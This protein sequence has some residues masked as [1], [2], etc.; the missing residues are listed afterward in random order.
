[1]KHTNNNK[2][3]NSF[4]KKI[5][6]IGVAGALGVAGI[7]ST[8]FDK[9]EV[10]I[11]EE[12]TIS[13]TAEDPIMKL[14]ILT[15]PF[16]IN[17]AEAVKTR[18]E[19]IWEI[20]EKKYDE[21]DYANMIYILAGK[22]D[23]IQYPES[24]KT[25]AEKFKYLQKLALLL[26]STLD[27]DLT[28]YVNAE[29]EGVPLMAELKSVPA[30]YMFMAGKIVKEKDK[31]KLVATEAALQGIEL[32]KIIFT[33]KDN[34]IK[35][36]KKALKSTA[37]KFYNFYK[38]IETMEI[39]D[40]EKF[41]LYKDVEATRILF[42][43]ILTKEQAEE[44]DNVVG[45][46]AS[47]QNKIFQDAAVGLDISKIINEGNYG[48]KQPTTGEYYDKN[49]AQIAATHPAIKDENSK[50]TTKVADKG[51]EKLPSQSQVITQSGTLSTTKTETTTFVVEPTTGKV[52]VTL[53]NSDEEFVVDITGEGTYEYTIPGGNSVGEI[54]YYDADDAKE[55]EKLASTYTLG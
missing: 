5:T 37:E 50:G 8:I 53:P 40:S 2:V 24:A 7:V 6:A 12:T 16:D 21:L 38:S 23:G 10:V 26:G 33:H 41:A 20:S 9:P 28:D 36:D 47:Y 30:I 31:E 25:D 45:I 11:D 4:G 34:I 43:G 48:K 49:D 52:K 51:G 55:A 14:L 44:I 18:A 1:M 32:R 19:A 17:D 46:L 29:S 42:T 22:K 54:E 39:S 35:N 27:D 3:Y 15:E 13:T